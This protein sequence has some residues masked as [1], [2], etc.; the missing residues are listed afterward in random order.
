MKKLIILSATLIFLASFCFADE[1]KKINT[2]EMKAGEDF[3][4]TLKANSTTGYQW[5]FSIP[6]NENILQLINSEYIPYKTR[7]GYYILSICTLLGEK[8]RP[9]KRSFF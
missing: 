2:I 5:Q 4:I 7:R 8:C 1:D 3:T 6:P 9:A